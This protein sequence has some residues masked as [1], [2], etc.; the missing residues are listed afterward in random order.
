MSYQKILCP[1]DFSPP[2]ES[3]LEAAVALATQSGGRVTVLHVVEMP[4]PLIEKSEFLEW[5]TRR[6]EAQLKEFMHRHA[7][8]Q[9]DEQALLREGNPAPEIN[10]AAEGLGADVV[11]L[12]THGR[13]GLKRWLLGSVAERVV[14]TSSVPSR[15]GAGR[16]PTDACTSDT[17][18]PV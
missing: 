11:V 10:R 3:A 1:V 8:P 7:C 16:P 17:V 2:S 4:D 12:G 6:Y 15:S 9:V 14:R 18:P 13:A 5:I